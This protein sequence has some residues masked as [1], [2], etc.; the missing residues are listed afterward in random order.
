M[1]YNFPYKI[2]NSVKYDSYDF[3]LNAK[4]KG[5]RLSHAID[6]IK[7]QNL[8]KSKNDGLSCYFR[9]AKNKTSSKH[10]P[11]NYNELL[12]GQNICIRF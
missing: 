8:E 12:E 11:I 7:Y 6:P 1:V 9:S 5:V 3:I 4:I 2:D 10:D